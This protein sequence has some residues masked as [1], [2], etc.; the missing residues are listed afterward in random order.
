MNRAFAYII[1][2]LDIGVDDGVNVDDVVNNATCNITSNTPGATI[3]E[4]KILAKDVAAFKKTF[5][6]Q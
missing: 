5:D 4:A 1:V 2:F 3:K 6:N